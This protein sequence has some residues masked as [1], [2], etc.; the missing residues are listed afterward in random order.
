MTMIREENFVYKHQQ[1]ACN[2]IS[3]FFHIFNFKFRGD[4]GNK[5]NFVVSVTENSYIFFIFSFLNFGVIIVIKKLRSFCNFVKLEKLHDVI[6]L[7][8]NEKRIKV[9]FLPMETKFCILF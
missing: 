4:K 3:Y 7:K 9:A 6:F 5:K 8:N 1:A 2:I